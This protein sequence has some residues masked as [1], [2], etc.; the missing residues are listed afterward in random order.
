MRASVL[1]LGPLLARLARPRCRCPAA[2]PLARARWTSTSKA[3]RHGRRDRGRARL[4]DRQAARLGWKR[5]KGARIT[6]D[7][8]TVTGTEKP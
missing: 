7:M 5:L 2:A 6:T 3:C 1:A 8:V 4:H